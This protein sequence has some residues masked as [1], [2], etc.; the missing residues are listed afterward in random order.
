MNLV[1]PTFPKEHSCCN[2]RHNAVRPRGAVAIQIF[3]TVH[4]DQK[5]L[6]TE[7]AVQCKPRS[8]QCTVRLHFALL[9]SATLTLASVV[10]C[11]LE[12]YIQWKDPPGR[13]ITSPE[14]ISGKGGGV[15]DLC[16]GA[17]PFLPLDVAL[18]TGMKGAQNAVFSKRGPL[19]WSEVT[20]FVADF[21]SSIHSAEPLITKALIQCMLS[22]WIS[23]KC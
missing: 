15:R 22:K 21:L 10:T 19:S 11:L 23:R 2:I 9:C 1:A 4:C 6:T 13:F 14:F 18:L 20:P 17:F 16:I 8:R 12:E 7:S 5:S 3:G